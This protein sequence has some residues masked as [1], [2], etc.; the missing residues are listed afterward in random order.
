MHPTASPVSE[1]RLPFH[2]CLLT[3]NPES[4]S[5]IMRALG[6]FPDLGRWHQHHLRRGLLQIPRVHDPPSAANL[7]SRTRSTPQAAYARL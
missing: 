6:P 4:R 3:N 2:S 5:L 7:S 1:R